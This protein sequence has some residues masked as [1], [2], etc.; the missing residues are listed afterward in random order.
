MSNGGRHVVVVASDD[1]EGPPTDSCPSE[2]DG[3]VAPVNDGTKTDLEILGLFPLKLSG[4]MFNVGYSAFLSACLAVQHVNRDR[5]VLRDYHL[6][7]VPRD[8][9][10]SKIIYIHLDVFVFHC[11]NVDINVKTIFSQQ[12][13]SEI[14]NF[15]N[16][17]TFQR[18]FICFSFL[19]LLR[20]IV[21][22]GE[23]L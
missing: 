17:I 8:T 19:Q 21:Y 9:M 14:V 15:Y 1:D 4:D 2:I 5:N 18:A 11:P 20:K 10:V 22:H 16:S 7:L 3:V 12:V 6:T 23:I 13:T